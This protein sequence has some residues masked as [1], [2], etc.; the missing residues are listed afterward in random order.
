MSVSLLIC[1]VC[2]ENDFLTYHIYVLDNTGKHTAV[3][4]CVMAKNEAKSCW[5]LKV[6]AKLDEGRATAYVP[7]K[8][9]IGKL[10]AAGY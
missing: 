1:Y 10:L 6:L 2:Y 7:L 4:M 9:N 3:V 5:D 8:E